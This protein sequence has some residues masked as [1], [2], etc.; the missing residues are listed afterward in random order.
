MFKAKLGCRIVQACFLLFSVTSFA[1]KDTSKYSFLDSINLDDLFKLREKAS[2]FKFQTTYL[3]N[4]V[5]AGRK[6]SAALPY[7]TPSIEYNHK[8][9]LYLGASISYLANSNS[10]IDVW[11]LD[12]GYSFDILK[13]LHT[14]LYINKPFYNS[15]SRNVQSNVSFY[16]GGTLSYETKII[17]ISATGNVMFGSESDFSLI[18]SLDH[19]FSWDGKKDAIWTI[20][21]MLNTYLG[22]VGFYQNYKFQR[23]N[24]RNNLP[25]T[26]NVT[27]SSPNQ[28][29]VLSY[30]FSL[31][32]YFDKTKW[33]IFLN[34]TFA[35]P[36]NPIITTYKATGPYGG[37]I[38]PETKITENISNSLFA[39]FGVYYKF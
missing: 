20:T 10:R 37:V 13:K 35:I 7:F 15:N 8:S 2:Y 30:E 12:L 6:D 23:V 25:Q 39:E 14:N 38:I 19:Q 22:S 27:I 1:Q 18:L 9:G 3:T 24:P 5:Y 16:T 17:N 21:P 4:S 28:F 26:V 29:Q 11:S 36:V 32:I 33:G 34:P 31:P